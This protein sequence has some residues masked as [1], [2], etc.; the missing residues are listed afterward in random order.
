MGNAPLISGENQVGITNSNKQT[1]INRIDCGGALKVIIALSAS[2]DIVDK[3]TD[4]VTVLKHY[5]SMAGIPFA[6][7]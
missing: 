2:A 3:P 5:G 7:L 1:N 4:I 6:N